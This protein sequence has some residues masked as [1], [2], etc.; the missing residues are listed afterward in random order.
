MRPQP[1]VERA[2]FDVTLFTPQDWRLNAAYR[3]EN[4]TNTALPDNH[5][6]FFQVTFDF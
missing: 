3:F 2:G 5:I 6:L 4:A 1:T